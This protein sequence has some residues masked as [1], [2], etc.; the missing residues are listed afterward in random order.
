MTR[1]FLKYLVA[2][3]AALSAAATLA[4]ALFNL[5]CITSYWVY[6]AIGVVVVL[7]L[8]I[9][10]ACWQIKSKKEIVLNLSS[11]MKLTISEGDLFTKKGVICIPF[12]EYFDTH[13]GDGVIRADSVHGIFINTVFKDRV[14]ELETRIREQLPVRGGKKHARRIEGCPTKRYELGTCAD[15][16]EGDN[17]YVLVALTHFDDNDTASV[18]RAE[19]TE[20]IN[21]LLKHLKEIAEDRPVYMPLMGSGLSRMGRT[22][23]RI[24]LHLVDTMDFNDTCVIPGGVHVLIKSLKKQEVNLSTLEY[25]IKNGIIE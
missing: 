4:T 23:Q 11:D 14:Q 18:S 13:V 16:Q 24:L 10:Y 5:Q 20:V 21:K 12:N 7:V 15:I 22:S 2:A 1:L 3:I 6:G 17:I 25:N 8:S 9:W 19:Y